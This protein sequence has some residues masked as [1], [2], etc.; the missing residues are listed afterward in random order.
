MTRRAVALAR[1]RAAP[2]VAIDAIDA[3]VEDS[4]DRS[5]NQMT[6]GASAK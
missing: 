3:A 1:R 5:L 4:L 6:T 2:P